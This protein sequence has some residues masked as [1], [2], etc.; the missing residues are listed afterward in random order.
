MSVIDAINH[1]RN[2]NG[3]PET[4]PFSVVD[5]SMVTP[6][7]FDCVREFVSSCHEPDSYQIV[8]TN[9]FPATGQPRLI[10]G[11][12][13]VK[14]DGTITYTGHCNWTFHGTM[15]GEDDTYDFNAANRGLL[16]ETLTAVGRMLLNGSGTPY[17]VQFAGSEPLTGSGHCGDRQ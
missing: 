15:R 1:Y 13:P 5:T 3:E 9:Y 8:G 7:K 16:G 14:L 10:V 6:V 17:M 12:V 4:L 11:D 2:G